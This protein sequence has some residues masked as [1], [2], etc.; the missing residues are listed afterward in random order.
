MSVEAPEQTGEELRDRTLAWLRENLPDGWME[1][2]DA[3]DRERWGSAA[4]HT[5]LRQVVHDVR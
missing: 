2:I 5:R 4:S 3:D 1:A